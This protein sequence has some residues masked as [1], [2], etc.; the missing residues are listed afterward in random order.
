MRFGYGW[1]FT[2]ICHFQLKHRTQTLEQGLWKTKREAS[3]TGFSDD[4]SK[5]ALILDPFVD[6]TTCLQQ[7]PA[8]TL[9]LKTRNK[10][11]M[12][13][14]QVQNGHLMVWLIYLCVYLDSC[15]TE[16]HISEPPTEARRFQKE[17]EAH[18]IKSFRVCFFVKKCPRCQS[19]NISYCRHEPHYVG[20]KD[21]PEFRKLLRLE[22]WVST[23][24]FLHSKHV[25]CFPLLHRDE[26]SALFLSLN[27]II[28]RMQQQARN[29]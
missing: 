20:M 7:Q 29:L 1:A 10:T 25:G 22:Q 19:L 11:L 5:L 2:G 21:F 24:I 13:S 17:C 9:R 27:F 15:P 23:L 14:R 12:N 8:Q 16:Q 6:W 26:H 18:Q 3:T 4:A 28:L